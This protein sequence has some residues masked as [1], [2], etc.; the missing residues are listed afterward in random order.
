M[1]AAFLTWDVA[2][3][4]LASLSAV[5]VIWTTAARILF[6]VAAAIVLMQVLA[7]VRKDIT[8]FTCT[9]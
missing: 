3:A 5:E 7:M 6:S 8:C 2:L 1:E 9:L 4:R